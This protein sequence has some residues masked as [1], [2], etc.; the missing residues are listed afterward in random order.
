M[1]FR[2]AVPVVYKFLQ[3]LDDFIALR[4]SYTLQIKR[5]K[6]NSFSFVFEV[7]FDNRRHYSKLFFLNCKHMRPIMRYLK[8]QYFL[9]SMLS[10]NQGNY[11]VPF[12]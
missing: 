7:L 6:I 11:L 4:L 9:F 10:A 1:L 3:K 5:Y 2:L 8:S 12:L